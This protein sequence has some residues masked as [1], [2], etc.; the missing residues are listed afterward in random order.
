MLRTWSVS[1]CTCTC[2]YIPRVCI[3]LNDSPPLS[4]VVPLVHAGLGDLL[5]EVLPQLRLQVEDVSSDSL[6]SLIHRLLTQ[7]GLVH[8]SASHGA[9]LTCTLVCVYAYTHSVH[10]HVRIYIVRT[11]SQRFGANCKIAVYYVHV[12]GR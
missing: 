12:V 5:Q 2:M 3:E 11:S 7:V 6:R 10:V 8:Q 1:V 9:T 4:E